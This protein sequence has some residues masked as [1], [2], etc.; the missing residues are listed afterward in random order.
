MQ[1]LP[2]KIIKL[3]HI[4]EANIIQTQCFVDAITAKQNIVQKEY[5][6]PITPKHNVGIRGLCFSVQLVT[7]TILNLNH[8]QKTYTNQG[9]GTQERI[10]L[11]SAN[12]ARTNL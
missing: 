12:T 10:V 1:L 2:Y 11:F 5:F 7:E 6:Q 4:K 9:K 8:I 3:N